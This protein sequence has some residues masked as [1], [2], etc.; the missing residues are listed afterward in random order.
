MARTAAGKDRPDRLAAKSRS[1]SEWPAL[2]VP[3][4]PELSHAGSVAVPLH[5]PTY[6]MVS[7]PWK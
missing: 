6:S 2:S 4:S 3:E 5:A 7:S 1:Q